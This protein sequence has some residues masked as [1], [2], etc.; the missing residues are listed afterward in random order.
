MTQWGIYDDNGNMTTMPYIAAGNVIKSRQ[1]AYNCDNMPVEVS[2]DGVVAASYQYDGNGTRVVKTEGDTTTHYVDNVYE[3]TDI[4]TGNPSGNPVKYIFA[5]N[6]RVARIDHS[7][8][9]YFHKDHLGSSSVVSNSTGAKVE[10]S[11]YLPYGIERNQTGTRTATYKFTDQEL[12]RATGLY[13]YDA[14]LYDPL[15][16]LFVTADSVIPDHYDPLSLNRYA[17]CRNN[18]IKY[19]DPDGHVPVET[20]LDIASLIDS[21][22]SMCK[23]PS[24]SNAGWLAWDVVGMIPYVPGSWAGKGV[25]Y[26]AEAVGAVNKG[27]DIAKT[28]DNVEDVVGNVSDGVKVAGDVVDAS[29]SGVDDIVESAFRPSRPGSE[30]SRLMQSLQ[31]KT[32]N[33]L[34]NK[35]YKDLPLHEETAE[36]IIREVSASKNQIVRTGT[37]RNGQVYTEIFDKDTGRGIRTIDNQFDTFVNID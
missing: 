18:P 27:S 29:K 22:H 5:G 28:V 8:V 10:T 17:Y 31:K 16:G 35:Y 25:K 23:D 3:V 6:L 26:G 20:I 4:T 13:N 36:N 15:L 24:W 37:N 34:K 14:R 9:V 11:G 2:V 21:V 33:P 30:Q 7:G 12:D 32:G 19:T 1:I